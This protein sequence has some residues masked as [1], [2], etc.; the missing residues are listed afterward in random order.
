M[1]DINMPM[2]DGY[3]FTKMYQDYFGDAKKN[4]AIYMST[5]SII[6]ADRRKVND[7]YAIDGFKV[8]GNVMQTLKEIIA[9]RFK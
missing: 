4:T 1:V 6:A 2:K 7:Y 3:A 9:E 8:K 5:S